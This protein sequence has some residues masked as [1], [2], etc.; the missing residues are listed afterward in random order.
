VTTACQ[1]SLPPRRPVQADRA[2]GTIVGV[3]ER[4]V[5]PRLMG[6]NEQLFALEDALLAAHRGESLGAARRELAQLFPQLGTDEPVNPVGDPTQAKLRLFEAVVG[7]LGMAARL[8]SCGSPTPC[9][10]RS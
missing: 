2:G 6:R 1:A 10:T 9:A 7:L 5:C 4:M 8:S 3:L